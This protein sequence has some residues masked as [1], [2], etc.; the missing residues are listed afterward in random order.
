M[1]TSTKIFSSGSH[2]TVAL[3]MPTK[4]SLIK[5]LQTKEDDSVLAKTVKTAIS[6]D[7]DSR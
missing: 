3:I 4:M 7:L 1:K 6:M 2:V 5:G